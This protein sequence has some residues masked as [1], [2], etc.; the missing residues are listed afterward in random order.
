MDRWVMRIQGL[1]EKK[2]NYESIL[3]H[4]FISLDKEFTS[5][6]YLSGEPWIRAAGLRVHQETV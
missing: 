6:R 2:W 3:K 4:G 1:E 5:P